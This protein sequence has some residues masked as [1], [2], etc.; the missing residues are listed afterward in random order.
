MRVGTV[1]ALHYPFLEDTAR[2]SCQIHPVNHKHVSEKASASRTHDHICFWF[3]HVPVKASEDATPVYTAHAV[4]LHPST[5]VAFRSITF[6]TSTFR[7][8]PILSASDLLV[9]V[10]ST[11]INNTLP[12]QKPGETPN[13]IIMQVNDR[14]AGILT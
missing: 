3:S 7:D 4:V 1:S 10:S 14:A 9:Y 12:D 8:L 2:R 5:T 13:V 6:H 11:T